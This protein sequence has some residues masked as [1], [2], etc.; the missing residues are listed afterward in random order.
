M[1]RDVRRARRLPHAT[2]ARS[3]A[4]CRSRRRAYIR[5]RPASPRRGSAGWSSASIQIPRARRAGSSP[6]VPPGSGPRA[7]AAES[8]E[9]RE[10]ALVIQFDLAH[11]RHDGRWIVG[12]HDPRRQQVGAKRR[13]RQ[14]IGA[15]P[16]QNVSGEGRRDRTCSL[17]AATACRLHVL[18]QVAVPSEAVGPSARGE[19]SSRPTAS[20]LL[21]PARGVGRPHA[22]ERAGPQRHD[23]RRRH[24]CQHEEEHW[25]RHPG[26]RP[27]PSPAAA[28][29][30]GDGVSPAASAAASGSPPGSAADTASA[31]AGRRP[32]SGSRHRR[33]TRSIPGS[34]ALT[35]ADGGVIDRVS[36]WLSSPT[37]RRGERTAAREEL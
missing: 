11:A 34:S 32:G 30:S 2:A 6:L 22:I 16:Y 17:R 3:P 7:A 20:R 35:I 28:T 9:E 31:D 10:P 15:L 19:T 14:R 27:A 25:P 33:M 24:A 13:G 18:G 12:S 36:C 23:E 1:P 5:P 8:T 37:G 4:T 29:I 26:V 21:Q